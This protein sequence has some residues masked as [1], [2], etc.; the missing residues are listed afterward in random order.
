MPR[1]GGQR[2]LGT[3]SCGTTV[4]EGMLLVNNAAGSGTGSG[5]VSVAAGAKL[6]GG[7]ASRVAARPISAW[8]QEASWW[9]GKAT[10]E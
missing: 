1:P 3:Y 4:T 10:A 7:A 9:W 6:G 5:S 8:A 2:E